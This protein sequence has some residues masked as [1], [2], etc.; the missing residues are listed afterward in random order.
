VVWVL[1]AALGIPIWL[2]VG[3]L[4]GIWLTR[5]AFKQQSG[6]FAVAVRNEN[7]DKWPRQVTYG[8][9]VRDVLLVNRGVALLRTEIHAVDAADQLE[10]GHG[11]KKPAEAVGRLVTFDDGSRLELAL[12]PAD[13]VR[14]DAAIAEAPSAH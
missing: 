12:A 11:P 6:V 14:L 1:L 5:R 4:I 8:R 13:A 9:L 2:V 7:D 3:V 10:I